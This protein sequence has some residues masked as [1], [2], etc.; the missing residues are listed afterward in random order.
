MS[1][2]KELQFVTWTF[3]FVLS[4]PLIAI[5]VITNAGIPAVSDTLVSVKAGSH[6]IQIHDPSGKVVAQINADTVWPIAGVVTLEFG[7]NDL[8]YQP[9]HTGIDIAGKF[10]SPVTTFMRG[11]VSF[12]GHLNWGYGNYVMI[13]HGNNITSLY[14][15]LSETDVSLEQTVK[16][17]DVIGREGQSGWATGP[18]VHFEVRAY[19]VPINPRTFVFGN[20]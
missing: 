15:H 1:L 17:G 9:V 12:I 3:I 19:D 18:H 20:P 6:V 16:P 14:G 5:L 4:L 10:G 13:D 8:P 2:K 11:K 7:A